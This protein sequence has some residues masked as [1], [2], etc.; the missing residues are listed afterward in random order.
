MIWSLEKKKRKNKKGGGE[1]EKLCLTI[2]KYQYFCGNS[3][4][5]TIT[6]YSLKRINGMMKCSVFWKKFDV[7]FF[8][9]Q[10][11]PLSLLN[12]IEVLNTILY[13]EIKWHVVI[14]AHCMLLQESTLLIIVYLTVLFCNFC[15]NVWGLFSQCTNMWTAV[16]EEQAKI[17]A[18]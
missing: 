1:R 14:T 9:E 4:I 16:V 15:A 12:V 17:L 2:Y 5:I 13:T 11:Q 3:K 7:T 8:T 10:Q 18:Y 6:E